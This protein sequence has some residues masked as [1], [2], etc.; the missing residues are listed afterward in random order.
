MKIVDSIESLRK[1][2]AENKANHQTVGF[3]P[4]M[5]FL[6]EGHMSLV[7]AAKNR[8]DVVVMSIF[9]N[10]L[11][12][13]PT[14][15]LDR[16][17]RNLE[18]DQQ[19]AEARGVDLLFVPT[20]EEMYP[21]AVKTVIHVSGVTERLCGASRPGH[22]DG[23]ATVVCK[24]FNMVQPDFAFFGE[25]DAQQVAVIQQMVYD[26]NL[27]IEIVPC[28]IVRE[29]DGL[30]MSSRNVYLNEEERKQALSLSQALREAEQAY[31]DGRTPQ[32]V[33]QLMLEK[34][35][36]EPLAEIDY[37]ELL[38]YP[39]LEPLE[40]LESSSFICA[41]AVRFGKTRLID[42]LIILNKKGREKHVAYDDD[43]K[44]T[45]CYSN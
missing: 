35:Q 21:Q 19:M 37:V 27:P 34:I 39:S 20:V 2:V 9:V 10:P 28:P 32:E 11:Q 45:P 22:F 8:A 6:H 17:P 26:L 5:G 24:L 16:Y 1:W 43:R 18:R 33:R 42:N 12:F 36:A 31:L 14:E 23:V 38:S 4:T 30:A 40:S 25:K 13:G 15:D 41:L 29:K 44:N 3:V 7:D